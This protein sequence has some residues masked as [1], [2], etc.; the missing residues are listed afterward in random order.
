MNEPI[1]LSTEYDINR[2][3]FKHFKVILT[4]RNFSEMDNLYEHNYT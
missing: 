2:K 3:D 1:A 4:L